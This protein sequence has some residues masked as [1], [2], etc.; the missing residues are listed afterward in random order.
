MLMR[1]GLIASPPINLVV[2][3]EERTGQ[4]ANSGGYDKAETV[5]DSPPLSKGIA[6]PIN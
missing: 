1:T 4:H 5:H 6:C 3:E 2:A